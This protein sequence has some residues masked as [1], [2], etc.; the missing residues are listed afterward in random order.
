[1][2]VVAIEILLG[3]AIGPAGFHLVDLDVP[4]TVLGTIGLGYLLF[5]AGLDLDLHLLRSALGVMVLLV[6]LTLARVTRFPSVW[7]TLDRFADTSSQ[8]P[9]CAVL[10]VLLVFLALSTSLGLRLPHTDLLRDG[11]RAGRSPALF[12]R[13]STCWSYQPCWWA[14]WQPEVCLQSSSGRSL[15]AAAPWARGSSRLGTCR[16]SS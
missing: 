6:G 4:L 9:V 7:S 8:L 10:V 16:S 3:V 15:V 5:L 1:M 13:R 11:R 14:C 12:R 2:P